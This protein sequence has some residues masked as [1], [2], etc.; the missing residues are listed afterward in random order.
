LLGHLPKRNMTISPLA[1]TSLGNANW[2][3]LLGQNPGLI[4]RFA[5]RVGADGEGVLLLSGDVALLGRV[6]CTVAL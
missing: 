1:V 4:C 2:Y 6:F 5:A 3:N